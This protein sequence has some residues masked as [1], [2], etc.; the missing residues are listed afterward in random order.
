MFLCCAS[1]SILVICGPDLLRADDV[2]VDPPVGL[3][4]RRVLFDLVVCHP[5]HLPVIRITHLGGGKIL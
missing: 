4:H 2:G 1:I 3:L 5:D